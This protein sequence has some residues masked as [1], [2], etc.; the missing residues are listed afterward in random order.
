MTARRVSVLPSGFLFLNACRH[1]C[2][3]AAS[4]FRPP[5]PRHHGHRP[6]GPR[7]PPG[8][9]PSAARPHGGAGVCG[10]GGDGRSGQSAAFQPGVDSQLGGM[11][12]NEKP[13][14]VVGAG[15]G[16]RTLATHFGPLW[17]K[18]TKHHGKGLELPNMVFF[19]HAKGERPFTQQVFLIPRTRGLIGTVDLCHKSMASTG[20]WALSK[21]RDN[22]GNCRMKPPN[23]TRLPPHPR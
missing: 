16:S 23:Q 9:L 19:L 10:T 7:H 18:K 8:H 15:L 11:E 13:G 2:R 4:A 22:A 21:L 5:C 17:P 14:N 6:G 1:R 3:S 20:P 12:L